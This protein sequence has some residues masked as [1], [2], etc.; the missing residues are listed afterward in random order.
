MFL[1]RVFSGFENRDAE[2]LKACCGDADQTFGTDGE[3]K[4]ARTNFDLAAERFERPPARKNGD[5]AGTARVAVSGGWMKIVG[6][7]RA[8]EQG[9]EPDAD[10]G[11]GPHSLSIVPER[12]LVRQFSDEVGDSKFRC[13]SLPSQFCM[14]VDG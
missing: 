10:V 11:S 3:T 14:G 9:Q 7:G 8:A 6:Q 2:A 12:D 1:P 13:R 4:S 5:V